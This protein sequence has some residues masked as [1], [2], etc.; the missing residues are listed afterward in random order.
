MQTGYC[1]N[2]D[3][4]N[5]HI[6]QIAQIL[7]AGAKGVYEGFLAKDGQKLE[8]IRCELGRVPLKCSALDNAMVKILAFGGLRAQRIREIV[9]YLKMTNEFIV[10][11]DTLRAYAKHNKALIEAGIG[12]E[13]AE[14][15]LKTL[16][17]NA[18]RALEEI[19]QMTDLSQDEERFERRYLTVKVEENK[20]DDLYAVAQKEIAEVLGQKEPH[21]YMRAMKLA[22]KLERVSDR[23]E[24]VAR[25]LLYI[26]SGGELRSF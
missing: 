9:G 14:T 11:A 18:V 2:V 17:Q 1:D 16:H 13:R 6:R 7:V 24:A 4:I 5:R 8:A 3:E 19:V 25:L 10:T 22:R 21:H 15:P 23:A 20:G 26:K 12:L